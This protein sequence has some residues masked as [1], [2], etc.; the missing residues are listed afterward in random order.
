MK[1]DFSRVLIGIY[2]LLSKQNNTFLWYLLTLILNVFLKQC[3]C[4]PLMGNKNF[5]LI[6]KGTRPP[7]S[8]H[9]SYG[10][11]SGHAQA[12]GFLFASQLLNKN[13][14]WIIIFKLSILISISRIHKK[15]HTIQQVLAGYLLGILFAIVVN[16]NVLI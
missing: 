1:K 10:M 3:I 11:P 7:E 4:K 12:A 14:H 13:P 15:H 5:P 9:T 2:F 6:G 8:Y 16:K